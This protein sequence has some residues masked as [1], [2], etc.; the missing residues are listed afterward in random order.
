MRVILLIAIILRL[1]LSGLINAAAIRG[2]H[3]LTDNS[4][5]FNQS[6]IEQT[7]LQLDDQEPLRQ[8]GAILQTFKP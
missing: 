7:L 3:A 1:H 4:H 6:L 2:G 5:F 8:R